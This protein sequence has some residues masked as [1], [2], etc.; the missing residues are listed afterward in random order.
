LDGAFTDLP[1]AYRWL[2]ENGAAELD[3]SQ[4]EKARFLGAEKD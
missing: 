4:M 1:G 3:P 2:T